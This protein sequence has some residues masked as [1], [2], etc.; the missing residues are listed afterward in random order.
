LEEENPPWIIKKQTVISNVHRAKNIF[1]SIKKIILS[2]EN[3]R[4][5]KRR[6]LIRTVLQTKM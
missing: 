4:L 1:K 2:L 5:R 6:T 3:L